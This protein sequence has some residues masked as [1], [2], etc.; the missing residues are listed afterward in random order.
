M[1]E[2]HMRKSK[3][4]GNLLSPPPGFNHTDLPV[5]AVGLSESPSNLDF[6]FLFEDEFQ[7]EK[8]IHT[9]EA[10]GIVPNESSNKASLEENLNATTS[11]GFGP[12]IWGGFQGFPIQTRPHQKLLANE[13]FSLFS[14]LSPYVWKDSPDPKPAVISQ[15]NNEGSAATTTNPILF[16][17]RESQ[18]ANLPITEK[19]LALDVKGKES[20]VTQDMTLATIPSQE[21]DSR[22]GSSSVLPLVVGTSDPGSRENVPKQ[23]EEQKAPEMISHNSPK[24]TNGSWTDIVKN[25]PK[26]KSESSSHSV[27]DE[28]LL[29]VPKSSWS[30]LAKEAKTAKPQ[31]SVVEHQ[32]LQTVAALTDAEDKKTKRLVPTHAAPAQDTKASSAPY[33]HPYRPDIILPARLPPFFGE[34]NRNANIV[35]VGGGYQRPMMNTDQLIQD[36]LSRLKGMANLGYG[37]VPITNSFTIR[38]AQTKHISKK[39]G[40]KPAHVLYETPPSSPEADE[41]DDSLNNEI[42]TTPIRKQSSRN[43]APPSP[44]LPTGDELKRLILYQVGFASGRQGLFQGVSTSKCGTSVAE[45]VG[46][47]IVLHQDDGVDIG[48]LRGYEDID[49]LVPRIPEVPF[50]RIIRRAREGEIQRLDLKGREEAYMV[51]A[52]KN[53]LERQKMT[54]MKVQYCEFQYDRNKLVVYAD[55]TEWVNFNEFVKSFFVTCETEF[56]YQARIFIQRRFL[57]SKPPPAYPIDDSK[58]RSKA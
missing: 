16:P 29:Y 10:N 51:Q 17:L 20:K 21:F 5:A 53:L 33:V 14:S 47:Y 58:T 7:I 24:L 30:D 28:V 52:A 45:L 25:I 34:V 26:S 38:N 55:M 8:N 32:Q 57:G 27:D 23:D 2:D 1:D 4:D 42:I 39:A 46:E 40:S 11:F 18:I 56:Q 48:I 50:M 31:I 3:D 13:D 9:M 35:V 15:K 37:V 54:N 36:R 49:R 22:S 19:F 41:N 12:S 43:I 6:K 44:T